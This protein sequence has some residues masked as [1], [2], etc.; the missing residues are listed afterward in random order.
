MSTLNPPECVLEYCRRTG[1]TL[2]T[3]AHLEY[4]VSV[5]RKWRNHQ[6]N[7]WNKIAPY[8]GS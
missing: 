6:K 7:E 2:I 8:E 4:L 3:E 1:T 5:D